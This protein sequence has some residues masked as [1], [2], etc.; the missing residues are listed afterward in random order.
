MSLSKSG[1]ARRWV[2][3]CGFAIVASF[4]SCYACTKSDPWQRFFGSALADGTN[5]LTVRGA[6][7]RDWPDRSVILSR[8]SSF[9]GPDGYDIEVLGDSGLT[10]FFSLTTRF[11][12]QPGI[13]PLV[14]SRLGDRPEWQYTASLDVKYEETSPIRESVVFEPDSGRLRISRA[15]RGLDG[16]YMVFMGGVPPGEEK[17]RRHVVVEGR[18]HLQP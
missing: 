16:S 15:G 14:A 8:T 12:P 10:Q 4:A 9:A 18:F 17:I 1:K 3:L 11:R 2:Q 7:N 13:Y 6:I 5:S